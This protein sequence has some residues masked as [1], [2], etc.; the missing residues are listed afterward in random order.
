[1]KV[2]ANRKVLVSSKAISKPPISISA[3]KN[4]KEK[5]PKKNGRDEEKEA[6]A[7]SL[8]VA[9]LDKQVARQKERMQKFGGVPETNLGKIKDFLFRYIFLLLFSSATEAPLYHLIGP[10]RAALAHY[11]PPNF[12][13]AIK[14]VNLMIQFKNRLWEHEEGRK[15]LDYLLELAIAYNNTLRKTRKAVET[16]EEILSYDPLDHLVGL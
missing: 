5:R 7:R 11:R 15:L 6:V 4:E 2:P 13:E 8:I 12:Q 1:M 16:F 9:R 14:P 3:K 10:A